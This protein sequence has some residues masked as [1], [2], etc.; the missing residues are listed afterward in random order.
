MG[1]VQAKVLAGVLVGLLAAAMVL[2]VDQIFTTL[3]EGAGVNPLE[4]IEL[5]TYDWRLSATAQPETA[6]KDIALVEID[7]YLPSKPSA[8]CRPVALAAGHPC[9][10]ARLSRAS[11]GQSHRVRRQLRRSGHETGF[12]FRPVG[13]DGRR[14]RS[15]AHQVGQSRWKSDPAG[16]CDVRS[17]RRQECSVRGSG[18]HAAGRPASS[19]DPSCFPRF[20]RW[21]L[22]ARA[23]GT[24]CS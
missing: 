20:Q 11:A 18:I 14:V 12:R 13:H 8:E 23:S 2:T 5:K 1:K 9:G 7:E 3:G 16:G 19:S 15:G 22:Q 21:P 6:W 17:R 4:T 10:P 24:T